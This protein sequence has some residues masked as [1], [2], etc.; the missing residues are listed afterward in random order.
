MQSPNA[1]DREFLTAASLACL[2]ALAALQTSCSQS[3]PRVERAE[4]YSVES[5][6]A[7]AESSGGPSQAQ[8]SIRSASTSESVDDPYVYDDFGAS[9]FDGAFQF[10]RWTLESDPNIRVEQVDQALAIQVSGVRNKVTSSVLTMTVPERVVVSDSIVF[11][12]GRMMLSSDHQGGYMNVTIAL[13]ASP[14]GQVWW[15]QCGLA[16]T[17]SGPPHALCDIT[18]YRD[19]QPEFS[20]LVPITFD[21]WHVVRMEI[22]PEGYEVS[23]YLDG[24]L[25]GRSIPEDSERLRGLSFTRTL[26]T[27]VE[28]NT[29]MTAY[30]DD[31]RTTP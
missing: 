8:V 21:T 2:M 24:D 10:G 22:D 11:L 14:G 25:I 30:V 16:A 31:I 12:E 9:E 29:S 3:V 13:N 17:A 26:G 15:S 7:T 5:L 27:Y 18:N 28:S 6:A 23:F 4:P 20:R 19:A 1:S